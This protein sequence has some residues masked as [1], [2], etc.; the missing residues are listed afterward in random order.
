MTLLPTKWD[1]IKRL[2]GRTVL[3]VGGVGYDGEMVEILLVFNALDAGEREK[4]EGYLAHK[5]GL[6]AYLPAE[7]P[8]KSGW[9]TK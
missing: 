7:H 1:T 9:P 6:E 2:R 8:W 5:W 3:D 4:T